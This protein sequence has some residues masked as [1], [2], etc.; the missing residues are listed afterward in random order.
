M[1]YILNYFSQKENQ[2]PLGQRSEFNREQPPWSGTLRNRYDFELK[3]QS[4]NEQQ[5]SIYVH[6]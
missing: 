2:T 1:D 5:P 4:I 6:S 3:N